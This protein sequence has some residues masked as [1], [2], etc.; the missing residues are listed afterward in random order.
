MT[1]GGSVGATTD[2]DTIPIF[3]ALLRRYR[4]DA[5]LTQEELAGR[6][7]LS[8]RGITALECGERVKPH[9]GTILLLADALQLEGTRRVEF[10]AV[11]RSRVR[12]TTNGSEPALIGRQREMEVLEQHMASGRT[13][14]LLLAGEPGIG[15]TRLLHEA[16]RHAAVKGRVVL[17]GGCR[18]RTVQDP[19]S[20]IVEALAQHVAQQTPRRL[21]AA[22]QGCS[23][24]ARL[25]PELMEVARTPLPLSALPSDQERRLMFTAVTR[26]VT[27]AAESS[28]VVLILDDLQWA[29]H[30][31]V[32]LLSHLAHAAPGT[33]LRVI[34]AYRDT[35]VEPQHPVSPLLADLGRVGLVARLA[36]GPL[37][38]R[39]ADELLGHLVSDQE[40]L[41]RGVRERVL[42]R[43]DGVPFFLVSYARGLRAGAFEEEADAA[44][45]WSMVEGIR[46]RVRVLPEGTRE[47]LGTAAIAGRV[48]SASLLAAVLGQTHDQVLRAL[49]VA[50]RAG[51]L[52]AEEGRVYRFA[53]DVIREVIEGDLSVARRTL[54]HRCIA[55]AIE[56]L[57]DGVR[58]SRAAE[59]AWHNL[60]GDEAERA[61]PYVMLAGGQ[62][63][64]VLAYG[65]AEHY[66]RTA[67]KT[68]RGL[69][70][71]TREAEALEKL[72]GCLYILGRYLDAL[73]TLEQAALLYQSL[74]DAEKEAQVVAEIGGVHG[75]R[76]TP[77][78]G[79][80]RIQGL[81]ESRRQDEPSH[82][83][84]SLWVARALLLGGSENVTEALL[85]AERAT[86][87]ARELR[88]DRLL[89]RAL[90]ARSHMLVRTGRLEEALPG[91]EEAIQ[92]VEVIGDL[93]TLYEALR[94]AADVHQKQAEV[95]RARQYIRRALELAE[96]VR[97]PRRMGRAA[98]RLYWLDEWEEARR[99]LEQAVALS[100]ELGEPPDSSADHLVYL[101]ELHWAQGDTEE[102]SALLQEGLARAER[103]GDASMTSFAQMIL[104][105]LDVGEG[106][107]EA[108]VARLDQ[109]REAFRRTGRV[110]ALA[111]LAEGYLLMG[112]DARAAEIVDND[113][114]SMSEAGIGIA[115]VFALRV[116]GIVRSH[117][118]RWEEAQ[119]AFE[120]A[121]SLG[122]RASGAIK[123]R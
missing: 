34:G 20:P 45:A 119:R 73:G 26:Y 58:R 96:Q 59:L 100:R 39:E 49:D 63:E 66:Y 40:R 93:E 86:G 53:H 42:E 44:P 94:A 19:Y 21:R 72:G 76:M 38:M 55:R 85:A 80:E 77:D 65:E 70:D 23:W 109:Y 95:D 98:W 68:A 15:K 101:G 2:S 62:A 113:F 25:L 6:A 69:G 33:R 14:V 61:L 46:Q 47:A 105:H 17:Q 11:G 12:Q 84:V 120:E 110:A 1:S 102:A 28:G 57:P 118:G 78:E 121:V 51:L 75:L 92:L 9:P 50:E 74:G 32:D 81:L 5:S 106:H 114:A 79:L 3:G 52:V 18:W 60:E 111:Q 115:L 16:A 87:L 31:A 29:G 108:A 30:D 90:Y 67:A 107:P 8:R 82:G 43:A 4:S 122:K 97:D 88:D 24:M 89:S 37:T 22:L 7:G 99:Y 112:G 64:S 91:L 35:E 54:L 27:N 117:Q 10:Q 104:A 56:Q 116:K 103:S 83:L 48:V 71:R 36:L 123:R 41:T 13:P